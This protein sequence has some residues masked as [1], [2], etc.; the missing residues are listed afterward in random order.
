MLDQLDN[1]ELSQILT[2]CPV[3][4]A[5][6]D[7][8]KNVTWVNNTFQS[9]L[10]ISSDEING[11]SISKLPET[12]KPLFTSS[13]AVHVPANSIRDDQWFICSQKQL[14]GN[15]VHYITDVG[16]IH[17]LMQEREALKN[18][19]RESLALDEVTGMPNKVAL[20]QSLEPQISRSRRYNNLLSI[21]ILRVNNL[22]QLDNAQTTSLLLPVSQMLNDQ[23]RWADIVGKLNHTDFLLVLPETTE[24]A[25]KTLNDNLEEKLTAIPTP[26]GLPDNFKISAS[27]GY[28]EWE[29][30]DDLTLLMKK[31][32]KMLG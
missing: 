5:L 22:N 9:Y 29:K 4:L 6:S 1:T 27:F 8:K 26:E 17:L 31:A 30:G 20:Y 3:G 15:T 7:D 11:Q 14:D 10:G 13:D 12:L 19:L 2:S 24:D 32:Q 23:V 21:V 25:C 28:A 18:E 16:P